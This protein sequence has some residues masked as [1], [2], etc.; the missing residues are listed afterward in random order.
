MSKR[1]KLIDRFLTKPKD[2][3]WDEL[4]RLLAVFGY[5]ELKSGKTGGSRRRF[6]NAEMEMLNFHKPHPGNIVM[7]YVLEQ[8][9]D[10]LN[11]QKQLTHE[12]FT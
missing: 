3:T 9:I 2:F 1:D 6:A 11:R 10:F 4:V 8:L 12:R 5:S 7:Q